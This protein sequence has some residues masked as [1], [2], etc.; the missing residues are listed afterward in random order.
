MRNKSLFLSIAI[1][2]A[3]LTVPAAQAA[4]TVEVVGAG[5]SAMWQT[6]G[7]GAWKDLAGSGAHHWTAKGKTTGG[8]NFA[9]IHDSR[10]SAIPNEGGNLWVVW[11]AGVTKVWAYLTLDSVVGNRSFFA[12]PRTTLQI[13]STAQSTAGQ[14]LISSALWGADAAALPAAVYAALNNH[15]MTAAF[16]DI[17]PEDAKF[18]QNR[19]NSA[20]NTTTWSGLGYNTSNPNIGNPILS[21]LTGSTAQANVINFN[22]SGTDPFT[23]QGI[24]TY[25]TIPVGAAPIVFI[26]NRTNASGLGAPGVYKDL[27]LTGAQDLFNGTQCDSKSINPGGS[28]VPVTVT[29][30]EPLSGTMNTTEFTNFRLAA[31]PN[32]S[33]EVG[34]T[35]TVSGNNPLNKACTGGGGKRQRAIGTSEVVTNVKATADSIGYAFFGYGNFSKI[36]GTSSYGYLTLQGVDP[37]FPSYTNGNLPTCTGTCPAT[38][39]TSFPHLRDGTYRSWSVLRV[40]TDTTSPNLSNTQALVTAI[41]NEVNSTVPDFVPFKTTNNSDPG[42][43]KYRSHYTQSGVTP[44]NGLSG[45]K[46]SGGDMGGCIETVGPAPGILNCHQ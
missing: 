13:D 15:A 8:A 39:G 4:V 37:I 32:N 41:Q 22:L 31:D 7:Y 12:A 26:I 45:Q 25:T 1:A 24:P 16:T 10:N 42:L 44:N 28:N 5:S 14:G 19:A 11:D 18:A 23:G 6:A 35:P 43:K 17:R 27:E 38:S 29:L 40:V 3:T 30:R 36:A 2:A 20:L 9:Q 33:Q 46:E 21:S 34:V